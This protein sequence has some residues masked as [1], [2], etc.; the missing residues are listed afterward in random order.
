MIGG[1]YTET[2][3]DAWTCVPGRDVDITYN[4]YN[5]PTSETFIDNGNVVFIKVFT[6]DANKNVIKIQCKAPTI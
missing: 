5:K 2:T 3:R 6:Y 1:N 4:E